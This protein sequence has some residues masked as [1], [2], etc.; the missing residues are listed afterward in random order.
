MRKALIIDKSKSLVE[1]LTGYFENQG[2]LVQSCGDAIQGIQ[3]IYE[4]IPDIVICDSVLDEISGYEIAGLVKKDKDLKKIYFVIYSSMSD[5]KNSFYADDAKTDLYM[6]KMDLDPENLSFL[7]ANVVNQNNDNSD[8]KELDIP[9]QE[10]IKNNLN[11]IY[12]D[13]T[14]KD[15]F[16]RS[17]FSLMSSVESLDHLIDSFFDFINESFAVNAASV[18]IDTRNNYSY[19]EKISSI[20]DNE[21]SEN[22]YNEVKN[23]FIEKNSIEAMPQK[24][25]Y[26]R[27]FPNFKNSNEYFIKSGR[28]NLFTFFYNESYIIL[29][30]D[31]N[32]NNPDEYL[33]LSY[34]I[35]AFDKMLRKVW[36]FNDE[37]TYAENMKYSFSKFIP[38]KI[39]NDLL[40]K[41]T[42]EDLMIGEKRKIAVLFSHIRNFAEIEQKHSAEDTVNFLNSHFSIYSA[43]IKKFGGNINKY[44]N[45]AVFAMFGAPESYENNVERCLRASAEVLKII[46]GPEK[47]G[48]VLSDYRIGIGIH[49][50]D[51]IIGN[52]G[53]RDSFDYTG[54]GDNINLAARLES[55]NKYY[56]TDILIS[57]EV[58]NSALSY[59]LPLCYREVD[60]IKV[61]G[62][63]APTT[64]Y[65]VELENSYSE[66]FI[67]EY[68]KGV[69]M[70][71]LGN[72]NLA[73]GF[74]KIAYKE[75]KKDRITEIYLKRC[76]DF[77]ET[78]P[79]KWDG[80]LKLDFK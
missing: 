40:R 79:E 62:R 64:V 48:M 25:F 38:E 28:G 27:K 66:K 57:E 51:V 70:F 4:N 73:L 44:I 14:I 17:I 69:K 1:E 54:I 63:T 78:P 76:E 7:C 74:F 50:G 36:V 80:A 32:F 42:D 59:D 45:D 67:E 29:Y 52:I 3:K 47:P 61:K 15:Y 12:V 56:D 41:K 31:H 58:K 13:R 20:I 37:M 21:Y 18:L 23:H 24:D 6:S 11:S 33:Y 55:L 71:R 9:S 5:E 53:S 10:I 39:I 43:S 65:S 60:T 34:V 35:N 49:E 19:F 16:N 30:I 26:K 46:R 8:K 72:W 2:I 68:N 77:I 22:M 75:N